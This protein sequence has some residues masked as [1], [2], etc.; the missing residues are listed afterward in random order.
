MS[1][2]PKKTDNDAV[3]QTVNGNQ[4]FANCG[5]LVA[6]GQE[7]LVT[8]SQELNNLFT[9]CLGFSGSSPTNGNSFVSN[10]SQ[11]SGWAAVSRG[12]FNVQQGLYQGSCSLPAGTYSVGTMNVGYYNGGILTNLKLSASGPAN[13]VIQINAAQIA[14]PTNRDSTGLL[15][16]NQR[17]YSTRTVIES[18][19]GQF[20]QAPVS[21][22]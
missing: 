14:S 6:N 10:P 18:V 5:G 1:A 11:Y 21:F 17:L 2:C 8:E 22:R 7:F 15:L 13:I 19:N 3:N 4:F 12:Q 9:L 16:M 20:C